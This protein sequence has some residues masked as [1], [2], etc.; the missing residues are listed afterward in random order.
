MS[1]ALI[2]GLLRLR[3]RSPENPLA[4]AR[5]LPLTNFGASEQAAALSRTADSWRFF[6]I[7][8][9]GWTSG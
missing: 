5:F 8:T 9:D 3:D 1:A 7:A 4:D 2:F 6:R